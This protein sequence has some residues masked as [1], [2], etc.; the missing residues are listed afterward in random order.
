MLDAS[1]FS[2]AYFNNADLTSP[3]LTRSDSTINFDWGKSSPATGV[4]PSTFSVRWTGHVKPTYG[5]TYTF[6][7]TADD[8]VRLWVNGQLLIDRW[9]DRPS[10]PGDAN[11]DGVVDFIDF[12]LIEQQF[13]TSNPQSDFNHDGTVTTADLKMFFANYGKTLATTPPTD[14]ATI[15]LA[16]GQTYDLTMEYYQNADQANAKLEWQSASQVRQVVPAAPADPSTIGGGG[17]GGTIVLGDGNGLLGTYYDNP[18]FTGA[19]VSRIDPTVNFRWDGIRPESHIDSTTYSVRWEGQV[20]APVDGNYTF[21]VNSDDGS[22]LWVNDQLVMDVWGD[23]TESEYSTDP[24]TLAAGQKY[25]IV[26]EYYQNQGDA[27]AE[28][29]W[30]GP[31]AKAIIPT[32]QLFPATG[33]VQPPVTP[34]PV[35]SASTLQV[36]ADGHFLVQSDGSPFFWLGDTAWS[37]FNKSTRADVDYYLQDRA[38][39]NYTVIQA[40]LFNPDAYSHNAFNQPV[41]LN[42][43]PS[44][45]NPAYFDHVDYTLAKAQSLG[46]Y[47][48]VLPTWGDAVAATDSRRVF[49]TS[50]AYTYGLWLGTRYASQPNIIWN[51]GG[52]WPATTSDVLDIWRALAAGLQAGDG[53][54]HLITFHPFGGKSSTTYWPQ[55]ESWLAF[56]EVQ[57]GHTRDSASY[58]MVA[59]DYARSPAKPVLDAE[60]NY[61]D[62]PNGLNPANPPLDDYDVR[63]KTYW[64]LFAGAFGATYG[65]YEV[66]QFYGGSGTTPGTLNWK[67]ALNQPGAGQMQY[68]R[69]LMQSRQYV[70]RVPDQS[71]IVGS[72][73]GGS[74][75][76]QATRAGD[77]SYG[78]IYSASGQS[79][80]V[81][82]TKLSGSTL[83]AWWYDPRTGTSTSVGQ[84][85]RRGTQSF[86]PPSSGYGKDWILVLD[87]V[88]AG[89]NAPGLVSVGASLQGSVAGSV[90]DA[91]GTI[92]YRLFRP[93]GLATGEKAP[94][95]LFLHGIG[96]RGTDNIAQLEWM[97]GLVNNTRSG[98]YAAYV[99]AP[100]IDTHS[101]FQSFTSTPTPAMQLT[102]EALDQVI[103]TENVD[104]SRIYVT[105]TSMGGMGVWDIMYREPNRF[106]AGV[107]MSGG[108][109]VT[110]ASTIKDIPV[111]AF[112][113]SDDPLVPVAD[114]RNMIQALRDAGGTPKY[115]EVAGGGHLIWD[116][117]YQDTSHTLYPWLFAQSRPAPAP[118]VA[119]P[120]VIAPVVSTPPKPTPTPTPKPVVTAP[121]SSPPK[122]IPPKPTQ[123]PFSVTPVKVEKPKKPIVRKPEPV[124]VAPPAKPK[125]PPASKLIKAKATK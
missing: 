26:L 41:F 92:P 115:T 116:P 56:N 4:D 76:I 18:D 36:S 45:P 96:D 74:D 111:W 81:D 119:T 62:I 20:L 39:K 125:A 27:V 67:D 75:H 85:A 123:P 47:V 79:F 28:L 97:G 110:T 21:Y 82:L 68:A 57:S 25:N 70:G 98:Q 17:G 122:P 58:N 3:V 93:Q 71:M 63:K 120:E 35:T 32:S 1:S 72:T 9:T 53:G 16:A 65:N 12:Q 31:I 6:Y 102:M 46:L 88:A 80:T 52:D 90:S 107:P 112:H 86:S 51:L 109:D 99:L 69:R 23:K 89:Y 95:I 84:F 48:D 29:R 38:N 104:T 33:P 15:A 30:G 101:W 64:D 87:D 19:Q 24:I 124:F 60:A 8:G 66:Y 108:G 83:Q 42:A 49:N 55:T 106:A 91:N 5:E 11:N 7:T 77:G 121:K 37:L 100:Q 61:E 94:L 14:S 113:G 59:S 118:R 40:V 10:L 44:T 50:N 78:M 114:T 2:A 73:L 34:P 43:N 117:I 105:G 22:R 13:N 103:N 54:M